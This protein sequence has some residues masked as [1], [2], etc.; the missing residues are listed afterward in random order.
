M[1]GIKLAFFVVAIIVIAGAMSTTQGSVTCGQVSSSLT[2]CLNYLKSGGVPTIECCNGV[3][4]INNAA[5]TTPDR[6]QACNCL[7]S[8]AKTFGVNEAFAGSLPSKC[9]VNIPYK[10]SFST[11]CAS[12]K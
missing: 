8:A 5:Q 10:I 11:N 1:A 4:A 3:K 7:K 6:Q 12:I 2:P 9:D